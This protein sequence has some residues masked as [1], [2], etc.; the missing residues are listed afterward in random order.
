MLH[1]YPLLALVSIS[2]SIVGGAL[3]ELHRVVGASDV[4]LVLRQIGSNLVVSVTTVVVALLV[5]C[6]VASRKESRRVT[7]LACWR[8]QRPLLI[9]A[10]VIGGAIGGALG[11]IVTTSVNFGWLVVSSA[12]WML[13]AAVLVRVIGHAGRRIQQQA[14]ALNASIRDLQESRTELISSEAQARRAVSEQLHGPVQSELLAIE[15]LLRSRGHDDEAKAI[16]AFRVNVVRELSHRLHPMI[17]DIGL[18]PALDEL[19]EASPLVAQVTVGSN[20]AELDDF[21]NP[22]L[23]M[24]ARLTIYRVVQEALLNSCTSGQ[25]THAWINVSATDRAITVSAADDGVG[26]DSSKPWGLG[27]RSI[28][29]WVGSLDGSWEI[30]DRSVRGCE[31]TVRL[32]IAPSTVAATPAW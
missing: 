22:G 21:G 29:A 13:I 9:P 10:A 31:L 27:L 24:I 19:V 28:D 4:H 23:S 14:D 7:P 3:Q 12:A 2:F 18:L 5:Q 11:S 20:V 15:T 30:K 16:H 8:S 1:D 25:A 17:I 32:P 6:L 26:L